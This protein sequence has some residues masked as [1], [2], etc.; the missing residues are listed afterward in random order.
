MKPDARGPDPGRAHVLSVNVGTGRPIASKSGTSGIDKRPVAGRIDVRAPGPKGVGGSGLAGDTVCDR[1][2][3]GGDD[4]A[5]YAYAREDLEWWETALGRSLSPGRFGENLTTS[6][7]DVTGARVGEHWRVGDDLVLAVTSPR[8]PCRT[9]AVWLA[10]EGWAA[11]FNAAG[12]PGAY[13]RV[14][15]PGT[16]GR[17]DAIEVIRRPD[18]DVTIGL[19]FR[20][21]TT[22]RHLR[23]RLAAAGDDLHTELRPPA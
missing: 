5:V 23:P 17:G 8:I 19:M 3:H 9:F 12:R 2:H 20:A 4:Q 11:T 18:H 22:E 16:V 14:L 21:L 6:G 13:L 1:D 15:A 7:L 10:E